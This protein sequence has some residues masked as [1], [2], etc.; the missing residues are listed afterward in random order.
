MVMQT[1]SLEWLVNTIAHEWTHNYLTQRPLGLQY[2]STPELRTMNETAAAIAGNEV[3]QYVIE[4]FYPE[5]ARPAR[6][7]GLASLPLDHPNPGDLPRP[8]FD[9]RAEMHLTRI[10]T[11]ALLAEGRVEEAEAYMMERQQYFLQNGYLIRKLN[12]AYFAF[13]GAYADTPGGAAGEDPVGPSV[14]AL[15]AQSASLADFINRIAWM[16]SFETL[17][18]VVQ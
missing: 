10:T 16:T 11:D 6:T 12:Q 8:P 2:G 18:K 3:G 7:S 4:H 5:L 9:F 15:R 1:T 17:Q 13:Y 14:R